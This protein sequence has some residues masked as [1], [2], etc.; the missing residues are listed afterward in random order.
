M[1]DRTLIGYA[2]PDGLPKPTPPNY[3]GP[4]W[5]EVVISGDTRWDVQLVRR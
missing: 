1:A 2:D 4:S 5:R 3:E